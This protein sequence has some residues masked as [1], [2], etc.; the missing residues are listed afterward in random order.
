MTTFTLNGRSVSIDLVGDELLQG[1][2]KQLNITSSRLVCGVGVCGACTV[3]VDGRTVAACVFPAALVDGS[4]VDTAESVPEDD[5]VAVAFD[6]FR[7]FQCGFCTPGAVME[8]RAFVTDHPE[9]SRD[10]VREHMA[11]NLCRCGCYARIERAV[12]E[13]SQASNSGESVGGATDG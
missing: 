8:A 10:E 7:A 6:R 9:P 1:V 5:P 11:G 3:V 2:L 4:A 12:L 13:A